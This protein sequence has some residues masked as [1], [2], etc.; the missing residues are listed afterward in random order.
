MLHF[1]ISLFKPKPAEAPPISS[2]T[3]MNFDGAEV[4]PFLNRLAENPR[5]T[6]PR[7]FAAAITQALPDLA[8]D[9]TRRWR[10]DGDFDGGAM[11][12]EIQIFMDDIDA[13]D[14]SFFSSAEVVAE[15]DKAL[16]QLD[17]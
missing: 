17:G 13:P 2:E 10:I 6:L 12:L 15:I 7:G 5:F 3:S 8:I 16:R 11:R 4:A 1:L 14:I 9:E